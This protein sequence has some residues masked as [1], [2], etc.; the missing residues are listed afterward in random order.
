ML[1]LDGNNDGRSL[2]ELIWDTQPFGVCSVFEEKAAPPEKR[3]CTFLDL[4][5]ENDPRSLGELM[6]DKPSFI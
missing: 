3:S 4:N 5:G 6:W 1:D 2:G